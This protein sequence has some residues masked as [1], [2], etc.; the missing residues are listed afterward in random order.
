MTI[1]RILVT[2]F[3]FLPMN[4][5]ALEFLAADSVEAKALVT[6]NWKPVEDHFKKPAPKILKALYEDPK[7]VLMTNFEIVSKKIKIPEGL[8]VA[9]FDPIGKESVEFFQDLEQYIEIA[10]NLYG[11]RY[12]VD[13]TKNDP[14]VYLNY[15][16]IGRDPEWF[17][18][19]GLLLSEFLAAKKIVSDVE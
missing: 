8:H 17:R 3:Q 18:P 16:D 12:I 5:P 4:A 15:Y 6:P 7:M 14:M 13:P 2:L 1:K 10:H 9:A 11:G 19:T